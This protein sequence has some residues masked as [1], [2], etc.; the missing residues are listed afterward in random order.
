VRAKPV[1][2][3]PGFFIETSGNDQRANK[4]PDTQRGGEFFIEPSVRNQQTNVLR[5]QACVVQERIW[6]HPI[7]KEIHY[8]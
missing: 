5:S 1:L 6:T 4:R 2:R 7:G 8:E 3:G